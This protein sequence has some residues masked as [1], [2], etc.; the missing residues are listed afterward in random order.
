MLASSIFSFGLELGWT[1]KSKNS[2]HLTLNQ[3]ITFG[4]IRP[5]AKFFDGGGDLISVEFGRPITMSI[6][7]E[8]VIIHS[9]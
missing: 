8:G 4:S 3:F 9:L 6:W 1:L 5:L 7:L 2:N